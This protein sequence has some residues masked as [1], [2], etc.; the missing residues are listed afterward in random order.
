MYLITHA[1]IAASH[2]DRDADAIEHVLGSDM[3]RSL[4]TILAAN[5]HTLAATPALASPHA[6]NRPGP[7]GKRATGRKTT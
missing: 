2:V 5:Q 1:D 3:V 7:Q 6:L 4:E